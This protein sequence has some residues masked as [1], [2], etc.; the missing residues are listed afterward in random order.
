MQRTGFYHDSRQHKFRNK[1]VRSQSI[2]PLGET[3]AKTYLLT[4]RVLLKTVKSIHHCRWVL[5]TG[6]KKKWLSGYSAEHGI[7]KLLV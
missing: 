4:Y 2:N 1:T 5:E 7:N 6:K 3:I